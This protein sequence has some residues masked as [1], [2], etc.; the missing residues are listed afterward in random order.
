M[1]RYM[2]QSRCGGGGRFS[3]GLVFHLYQLLKTPRTLTPNPFNGLC[4]EFRRIKGCFFLLYVTVWFE[5]THEFFSYGIRLISLCVTRFMSVVDAVL[6]RNN[7]STVHQHCRQE[8][9]H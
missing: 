1:R 8:L 6:Q 5:R 9:P 3:R 2:T 7:E 4:L